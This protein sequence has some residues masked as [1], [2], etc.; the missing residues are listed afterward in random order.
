MIKDS[1]KKYFQEAYDDKYN[2]WTTIPVGKE[3]EEFLRLVK[4]STSAGKMIDMGCGNGKFA[5]FFAKNGFEG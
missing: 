3:A 2:I 1:Q 4:K 5:I